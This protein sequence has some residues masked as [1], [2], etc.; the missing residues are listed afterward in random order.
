MAKYYKLTRITPK[1]FKVNEFEFNITKLL[2][3]ALGIEYE[4]GYLLSFDDAPIICGDRYI[5]YTEQYKFLDRIPRDLAI[6]RPIRNEKHANIIIDMFD[7]LNLIDSDNMEVT[8][9]M[10]GNKKKYSGYLKCGNKMIEESFVK[11]APS[12]PI[13]KVSIIANI[14]FDD[15]EYQEYKDN[16]VN[17]LNKGE[18]KN[19]KSSND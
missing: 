3:D 6:F 19:A 10:K 16:L 12:I 14:L 5:A 18:K 17:F 7:E 9:F 15:D 2:I 1:Q 4:S 8:E 13:L 11:S